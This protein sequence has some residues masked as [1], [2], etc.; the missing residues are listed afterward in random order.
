M[1]AQELERGLW[2]WQARH[3]QWISDDWWPQLVSSYAV[4]DGARLLLIDPLYPPA[5][6]VARAPE[7][8]TLIVLTCPWHERSSRD[9]AETLE[10]QIWTPP[11]DPG[12]PDI[13][14][15]DDHPDGPGHAY[16]AE[17][18][19][20]DGVSVLPG[21]RPNDVVLWIGS[22]NAVVFGDTL[23]DFGGGLELNERWL[24]DGVGREDVALP[25][26]RMLAE[27]PRHLLATH[28][29]PQTLAAF[30][31]ALGAPRSGA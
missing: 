29:G 13:A 25:L 4:D 31:R 21:Q 18:G 19:I 2:H 9:L 16:T 17:R 24:P 26:R 20:L 22:C 27:P 8:E 3:P 11:A 12:S 15:L 28:G 23:V 7:R 6:I 5:E 30:E 14:W 10:L 1:S